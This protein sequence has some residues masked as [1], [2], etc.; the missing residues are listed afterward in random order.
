MQLHRM[1]IGVLGVT[2]FAGLIL[3]LAG[4]ADIAIR[5]VPESIPANR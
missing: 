4:H 5:Q 2:L 3:P 1:A